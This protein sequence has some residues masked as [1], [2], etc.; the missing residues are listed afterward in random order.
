[1]LT[2]S[3]MTCFDANGLLALHENLTLFLV[4]VNFD[5]LCKHIGPFLRSELLHTQ[6]LKDLL[7][8]K[9]NKIEKNLSSERVKEFKIFLLQ[10]CLPPPKHKYTEGVCI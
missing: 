6:I 4:A 10:E 5:D 2:R 8:L 1:M 3:R 9:E 7:I